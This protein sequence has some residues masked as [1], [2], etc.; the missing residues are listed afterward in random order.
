MSIPLAREDPTL[1][2]ILTSH[3][4]LGGEQTED[5]KLSGYLPARRS[6]GGSA[7]ARAVVAQLLAEREMN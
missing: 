6:T 7:S 1:P 5:R 3:K 2:C 4:S